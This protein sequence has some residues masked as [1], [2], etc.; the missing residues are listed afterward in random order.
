MR[1]KGCF[2]FVYPQIRN[3]RGAFSYRS[4]GACVL[5]LLLRWREVLLLC[6]ELGFFGDAW[7]RLLVGRGVHSGTGFGRWGLEDVEIGEIKMQ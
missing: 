4:R 3:R 5:L 1:Q 2:G 6:E 7:L